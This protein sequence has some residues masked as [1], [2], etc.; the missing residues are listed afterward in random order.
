MEGKKQC[1]SLTEMYSD[2]S[3][4]NFAFILVSY[5]QA[6]FISRFWRFFSSVN[7]RIRTA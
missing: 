2:D 4:S 3:I 5:K 6:A 7:M 1:T